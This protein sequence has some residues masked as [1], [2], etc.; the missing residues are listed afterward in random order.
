[1]GAA[2]IGIERATYRGLCKQLGHPTHLK[3]ISLSLCNYYIIS[4][5]KGGLLMIHYANL[6][7]DY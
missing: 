3:G 5:L 4:N 7:L 1:M 2:L 6:L